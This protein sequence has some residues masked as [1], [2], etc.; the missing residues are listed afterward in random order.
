MVRTSPATLV[1]NTLSFTSLPD[2]FRKRR[3][4][5]KRNHNKSANKARNS[6][7]EKTHKMCTQREFAIAKFLSASAGTY[8]RQQMS[9]NSTASNTAA[10][11]IALLI[12]AKSLRGGG[13]FSFF[14]EEDAT[15]GT[16]GVYIGGG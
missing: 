1:G 2:K 12:I 8:H 10:A 3:N 4:E 9:R 11:S 7:L 15:L 6:V 16:F 14:S 13:R 5:T